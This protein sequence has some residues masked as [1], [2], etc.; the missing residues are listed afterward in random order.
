[1]RC[2][3]AHSSS[4]AKR[5]RVHAIARAKKWRAKFRI[6]FRATRPPAPARD[7]GREVP[8]AT[9]TRKPHSCKDGFGES[10]L[11]FLRCVSLTHMCFTLKAGPFLL[12]SPSARR[13]FRGWWAAAHAALHRCTPPPPACAD[14]CDGRH[15]R[16]Q[17]RRA[18]DGFREGRRRHACR[19]CQGEH[20]LV[21]RLDVRAPAAPRRPSRARARFSTRR[22]LLN[23][24]PRS[25][26]CAASRRLRRWTLTASRRRPAC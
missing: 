2:K 13:L 19:D 18:P 24:R 15:C 14:G 6:G 23:P 12:L 26:L 11:F 20:V 25:P 16:A 4:A 5:V 17:G 22:L 21:F 3:G 8:L 9:H 1:M 10:A 7:S